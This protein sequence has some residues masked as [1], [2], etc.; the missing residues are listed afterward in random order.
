MEQPGTD[1]A[2]RPTADGAAPSAEAATEDLEGRLRR[3]LAD[4]DNLRKRYARELGRERMEERRSV[5]SELLS[6]VQRNA[7]RRG[8]AR[9]GVR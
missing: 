6:V 4:L 9:A 8:R 2:E 5:S 1:T 7:A 3:A